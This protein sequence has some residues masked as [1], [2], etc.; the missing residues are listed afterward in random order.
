MNRIPS[1]IFLLFSFSLLSAGEVKNFFLFRNI[2]KTEYEFKSN[3]GYPCPKHKSALKSYGPTPLHRVSWAFMK[4]TSYPQ[5][6][7]PL[8]DPNQES[9]F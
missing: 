5:A 4:D 8:K 2:S 1:I 7:A 9:L 3:K 6:P